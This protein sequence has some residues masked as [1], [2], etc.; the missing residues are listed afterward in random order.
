MVI[1]LLITPEDAERKPYLMIGLGIVFATF[2]VLSISA[3]NLANPG[4]MIVA[5]VSI[6]TIPFV[7]S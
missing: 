6:I 3:L 1:E 5:M 2:A 4:I 7:Y